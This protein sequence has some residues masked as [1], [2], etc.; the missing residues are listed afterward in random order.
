MRIFEFSDFRLD[1]AERVLYKEGIPVN[2]APKVLDTLLV[3]VENHGRVVS[4]E[5]LMQEV[6]QQTFV[7]ENNL[8]QNIFILRRTLGENC[9]GQKII[10]TVPRRG[11]RFTVDV[12][13]ISDA[14]KTPV[15]TN[16]QS[17]NS[18]RSAITKAFD[19]R[20]VLLLVGLLLVVFVSVS[21]YSRLSAEKN[22]SADKIKIKRL[23]DKGNIRGATISPDGNLL[24]YVATEGK[25]YSLRLRNILTES[26]VVVVPPVEDVLGAGQFSPDGNFIYYARAFRDGPSAAFQVPVFGGEPRRIAENLMS[27][28]SVSPDG[29]R[30][31]FPRRDNLAKKFYIIVANTDGSGERIAAERNEPDYFALWGPAPAWSEDGE[32][33][34]IV[35]GKGGI[36]EN[37]LAEISLA[38]GDERE[39]KTGKNWDF[40]DAVVWAG[41]D[42][43][44][45]AAREKDTEKA[46][47]W[48]I[49]FPDLEIERLTNGF[50]AYMTASL[51]K[52]AGRLVATKFV[53]NIH[54]WL[55]DKE[56]GT[57]RQL[58]FGEDRVDGFSGLAFAPDGKIIFSARNRNQYDIFSIN[59]D[60]G[61]PRQLTKNAG[62]RNLHAV[63]SPDNRL[64]A[65]VSDRTGL[66]RVWL[67]N[68]DGSEARQLTPLSDDIRYEEHSPNFSPDGK[69]IY[70]T[71]YYDG[72]GS[73]RKIPLEG[74]DPVTI[75][76]SNKEEWAPEI[77]ADGKLLA[78][79]VYDS[80]EKQSWRTGV[81][82]FAN[83]KE[84][85]LDFPGFRHHKRWSP[86]AR[87][88][89][90]IEYSFYGGNLW[91]TNIESSERRQITNFTTAQIDNFAVS[92]DGRFFALARGNGFLDAVLIER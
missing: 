13:E 89:I 24:A 61:E 70:Y 5:R 88:L 72:H 80:N 37:F 82:N 78:F 16:L 3:L 64:I 27:N 87:F 46:Q 73:I 1:E 19:N 29:T 6:W 58:T 81:R 2:L 39:I 79:S 25:T 30:I 47:L 44:I 57:A 11:Y 52:D 59:A 40:I 20:F 33:L 63:V 34:T 76:T 32:H 67:M 49:S 77:S 17:E 4:K 90:S 84:T 9:D 31:A 15:K 12:R 86:D 14:A 74:G 50:D 53:E 35:T 38:G 60:G 92:P 85:F 71:F 21:F 23:T 69:W 28:F 45:M 66:K 7:E 48:R 83:N 75:S 51:T 62:R 65:F 56:T 55:F 26:E 18:R 22:W 68:R 91:Q 41:R 8:T 54:L 42:E 10:E 36:H 43:L